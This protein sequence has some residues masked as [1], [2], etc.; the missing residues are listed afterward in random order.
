MLRMI[1]EV[2][3]DFMRLHRPLWKM[4][5]VWTAKEY[6]NPLTK[7]KCGEN[8][9]SFIYHCGCWWFSTN[10][11]YQQAQWWPSLDTLYMP[12]VFRSVIRNCMSGMHRQIYL[13]KWVRWCIADQ[14][15]LHR[16]MLCTY[17][18]TVKSEELPMKSVDRIFIY[19]FFIRAAVVYFHP[20]H[21]PQICLMM[22]AGRHHT[23]KRIF[24]DSS[25]G[26]IRTAI[27]Q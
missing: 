12:P 14:G 15:E 3:R 16:M 25:W 11:C 21:S 26:S 20:T 17:L 19:S 27:T 2:L 22:E 4:A 23:P 6:W 1:L 10:G 24:G 7:Q 18:V 9:W 8:T 13:M 5:Y